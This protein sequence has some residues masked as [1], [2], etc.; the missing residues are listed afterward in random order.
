MEQELKKAGWLYH[1]VGLWSFEG[2]E[3]MSFKDACRLH[4]SYTKKETQNDGE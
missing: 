1:G 4:R 3:S 2:C